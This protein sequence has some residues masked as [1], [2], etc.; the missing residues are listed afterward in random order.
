[1]SEILSEGLPAY[2]NKV[3]DQIAEAAVA[4]QKAYFLL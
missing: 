2:L 1:L 4:V 3:Q